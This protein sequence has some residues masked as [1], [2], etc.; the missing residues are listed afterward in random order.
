MGDMDAAEDWV[1]FWEDME[2]AERSQERIKWLPEE[3]EDGLIDGGEYWLGA[4]W[5]V[6][7]KEHDS[8]NL[9]NC[10]V[11]KWDTIFKNIKAK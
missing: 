3:V 9:G 11:G 2:K 5:G 10:S 8:F 7:S 4:C 6:Y 1:E